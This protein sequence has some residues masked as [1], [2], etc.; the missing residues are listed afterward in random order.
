MNRAVKF[1]WIIITINLLIA[2][3]MIFV[4]FGQNGILDT[5]FQWPIIMTV[6]IL[7]L[8]VSGY[9]IG[10]K[11]EIEINLKKRNKNIIG[12]LGLFLILVLATF[13]G[14]TVGFMQF[15]IME[16]DSFHS[17]GDVIFDY[18]FKPFFWILLFGII[19]TI[20]TGIMLGILIKTTANSRLAQ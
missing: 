9:Y 1:T 11:M 16:L 2:A 7:T 6:G 5:F 18:Y 19:P 8:Y 14:A 10:K 4:M 12:V 3:I 20:V 17:I 15:G 13:T